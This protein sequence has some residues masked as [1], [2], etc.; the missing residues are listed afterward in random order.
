MFMIP[1][2]TADHIEYEPHIFRKHIE[3]WLVAATLLPGFQIV[4]AQSD[5]LVTAA[6]AAQADNG[7]SKSALLPTQQAEGFR[8]VSRR[9]V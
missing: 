6:Y 7:F 2:T 3:S 5:Q 8:A 4:L 9:F 1:L